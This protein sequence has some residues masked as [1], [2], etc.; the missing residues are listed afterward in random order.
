[1]GCVIKTQ[2]KSV[3]FSNDLIS[4]TIIIRACTSI[5]AQSITAQ[6]YNNKKNRQKTCRNKVKT[7][8]NSVNLI[9]NQL[10]NNRHCDSYS[11]C[12]PGSLSRRV[13]RCSTFEQAM[14]MANRCLMIGSSFDVV[15]SYFA[16]LL[17]VF[18]QQTCPIRRSVL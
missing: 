4:S 11:N 13:L 15:L 8:L 2:L 1:M 9:L 3:M 18:S 7:G 17:T 14:A 6:T 10:R 5:T 12:Y 16:S